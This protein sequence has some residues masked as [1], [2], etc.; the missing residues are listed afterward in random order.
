MEAEFKAREEE[1]ERRWQAERERMEQDFQRRQ[2]AER[3][4]LEQAI[5]YMQSLGAAIG[6]SLPPFTPP[7]PPRAAT[8][9]SDLSSL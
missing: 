2:E 6:H 8:P 5:Q 3:L 9:V 7:P 1:M 4:R